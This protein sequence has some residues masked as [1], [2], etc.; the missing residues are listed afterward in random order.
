VSWEGVTKSLNFKVCVSPRIY[1]LQSSKLQQVEVVRDESSQIFTNR[2]SWIDTSIDHLFWS[3]GNTHYEAHVLG[4]DPSATRSGS[5]FE[6][7]VLRLCSADN[8]AAFL[9][10]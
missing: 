6:L 4:I 10:W 9:A 3:I 1:E 7:S 8:S 5:D 2:I